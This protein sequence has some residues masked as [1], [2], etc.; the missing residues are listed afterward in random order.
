MKKWITITIS[1]GVTVLL[2][3]IA[4]VYLVVAP[5]LPTLEAVTDYQPKI[6]LR[7]YT[8]DNA[9]IGEFGEEHRDFVPIK[10]IPAVMKNA[11]LSIEDERFYEHGGISFRS[12]ARA[13]VA[14][15]RG[16]FHQ[17]G[18]TI[19][20]QVARNFFLSNEKSLPRKLKEILL[21]YRIED[22][23]S[24]DQILELY[25]NQIFL[26]QRSHG[27]SSAAKTYFGKSLDQLTLAEAAM[28]AGV[29]QNPVRHNPAVNFEKTK[30]RQLLVLQNMVRN[31][32]ITQ[33]QMEAAAKEEI[34][35]VKGQ[36]F[37]AHADYVAEMVRQSIF[38]QYKEDTY[39]K[40]IKVYTTINKAEQDAAYE[41]VRRNIIAYDQRHGYDG[42]EAH[43]ELPADEDERDDAIDQIL[44]KHP[45]NDKLLAAVV[46]QVSG[47]IV[48][49][50]LQS[51][52]SIEITGEG[53]RFAAAALSDKAKAGIKIRAGSVIRVIQDSK[54]RW[55]ITQIPEVEGSYVAL[56][57]DDG[58][59][60]AMVGGFDFNRKKFNHVT[61]AWRQPGSSI[62]PFIY[63]AALEKGFY[64]GTLINDV[65][66]SETSDSSLRWDPRND[67]GKYD[68][69]ISMR[70]ALAQS[71][72]V[73]SVRI[74]KSIG[75]D[76]ARNWLPRFG[77]DKDKHQANLTMALGTGSVTPLQLASAYA[78]F[79]NGGYSVNPW[80]ISK[81][82][83]G[84]GK[85][86]FENKP[87][88]IAQEEARVIDA[89]NAYITDNML[90]EVV[91]SGTGASAS[92]KLGRR[93]LAGKT[94]TTSDAVDGWFAGYAGNIV[95]VAWMGYDDPKSLGGREFGSTLA[96]PIW[97]DTMRVALAGKPE[98]QRAVPEGISNT[99]GDWMFNE[100]LNGS[101]VR[102]LDI[103]ESQPPAT[104]AQ[105]T[106]APAQ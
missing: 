98:G 16:G 59:F 39:T 7:I 15:L 47:K 6:P 76:T 40:G 95:A 71:K 80:L 2:S 45:D 31:G 41:A 58:S 57:A 56:N 17:G 106:Q 84:K 68:G 93:D 102:T 55:A 85:V 11:I 49:A 99:E 43:I 101:S 12:A 37:D 4:Y 97:I 91:L 83:D 73:V 63:S 53:L 18:S 81:V 67:D 100:F 60:R 10:Q 30:Q 23:L 105:A 96:L 79:A 36:Q 3:T 44:R 32:F 24:K 77:F 20:M 62:K 70:S 87:P 1:A 50:E 5:G 72:N 65:Q 51:G 34:K 89:R 25:M 46:T 88:A 22:A 14:D 8:A 38:A 74:L 29:P 94:G 35:V 104:P 82:V 69:P 52:D 28:L 61:S 86:L 21:T 9:L 103:T 13:V 19:T 26:G 42:P 33:A 64:P 66:L 78:V 48:K 75:V 92:V 54:K 27:F 90:R